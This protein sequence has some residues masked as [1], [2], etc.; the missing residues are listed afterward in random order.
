MATTTSL[1]IDNDVPNNYHTVTICADL[2]KV[3]KDY[4]INKIKDVPPNYY[5]LSKMD[6]DTN[7]TR[8]KIQ[9]VTTN[10]SCKYY[11]CSCWFLDT[12]SLGI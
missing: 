4:K 3:N 1:I 12:L 7:K 6:D 8:Y 11:E 9:H 5:W 10:G 2:P